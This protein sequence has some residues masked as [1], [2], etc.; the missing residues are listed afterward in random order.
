MESARR[1][2]MSAGEPP[3]A[4]GRGCRFPS[5]C[6]TAERGATA[7]ATS[8]A[9]SVPGCAARARGGGAAGRRASPGR[10]SGAARNSRASA[11]ACRRGL[12]QPAHPRRWAVSRRW[13][14]SVTSSPSARADA[15]SRAH[16]THSNERENIFARLS[17]QSDA[18]C[19]SRLAARERGRWRST[20]AAASTSRRQRPVG[21]TG[22]AGKPRGAERVGDGAGACRTRSDAW[23]AIAS[24]STA[25][26]AAR[27]STSAIA[28]SASAVA[29]C[30]PAS[31]ISSSSASAVSGARR[32]TEDVEADD[33]ARPLPDREQRRLP[34]DARQ[35]RLLDVAV[36]ADALERLGRVRRAALADPVLRRPRWR[37]ARTRPRAASPR[38]APVVGTR[39]AQR[40]HGR[41]LGLDAEVGEDVRASAAARRAACRRR[42]GARRGGSP[43]RPPRASGPRCRAR[44]RAACGRPSRGSSGRRGPPRRRAAPTPRRARPPRDAFERSPSLSLRRSIRNA[45][46][47]PSGSTRGTRKHESPAGACARTRN[48]SHIGAEQNHF[49][50]SSAY[51]SPPS[52]RAAVVFDAYVRAALALGHRHAAERAAFRGDG[53]QRGVVRAP[54]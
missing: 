30:S 7:Q 33:V 20:I 15:A 1:P 47:V 19:G 25:S 44:S 41:G 8:A 32:T 23:S 11:T 46:R 6:P 21:E 52:G 26:R 10:S 13:S 43:A 29:R 24:R 48:A 38:G 42:A 45:L 51:S 12:R 31:R 39:E 22:L 3:V 4:G 18:D 27:S 49:S 5:T 37:S 50:P 35:H 54:R 40:R 17:T 9:A 34:V 16:R 2:A 36:A 28:R 53:P 14:S